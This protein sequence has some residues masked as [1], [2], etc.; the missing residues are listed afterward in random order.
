VDLSHFDPMHS[1]HHPPPDRQLV[2]R[3]ALE[4]S[5]AEVS[6][7]LVA[8]GVHDETVARAVAEE[9]WSM[10]ARFTLQWADA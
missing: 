8:A 2:A 10:A 6:R 7:R 5:L 9:V 4:H 1:T 3:V